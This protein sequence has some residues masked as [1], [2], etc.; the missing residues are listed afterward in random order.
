MTLTQLKPLNLQD[1]AQDHGIITWAS[2]HPFAFFNSDGTLASVFGYQTFRPLEE[3]RI[4]KIKTRRLAHL[5]KGAT[6]IDG[7]C[8]AVL[9]TAVKGYH[10]NGHSSPWHAT[11][12]LAQEGRD[13]LRY[14]TD[15]NPN[16]NLK[17]NA[18]L[19]CTALNHLGDWYWPWMGSAITHRETHLLYFQHPFYDALI[20][21]DIE[22]PPLLALWE[23]HHDNIDAIAQALEDLGI[24]WAKSGRWKR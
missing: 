2:Y 3:E 13:L 19:C 18:Q 5:S 16:P 14:S 12:A 11:A 6:A 17:A 7:I 23:K 20:P 4:E 21:I 24:K 9:H 1:I 8:A 10:R 15:V 22:E